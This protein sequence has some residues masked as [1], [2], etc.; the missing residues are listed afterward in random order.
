VH[1]RAAR[2]SPT[3]ILSVARSVHAAVLLFDYRLM[4]VLHEL[5]V[6]YRPMALPARITRVS[7]Y[8]QKKWALASGCAPPSSPEAPV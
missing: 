4:N 5:L 1:E 2:A 7:K 8:A 3:R 6:A